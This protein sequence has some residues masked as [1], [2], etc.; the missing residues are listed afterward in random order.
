M[1][2]LDDFTSCHKDPTRAHKRCNALINL[3]DVLGLQ[4]ASPKCVP[5]TTT[6]EWLGYAIDTELMTVAV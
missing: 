5:P 4:L 3:A 6:I 2:Y 1:A